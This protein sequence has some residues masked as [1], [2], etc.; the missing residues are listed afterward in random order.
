MQYTGQ[1][2]PGVPAGTPAALNGAKNLITN[3]G[4]NVQIDEITP[5]FSA[6]SLADQWHPNERTTINAGIRVE[7]F[8]YRLDDTVSGYPARA[9]LVRCVRSRGR[10]DGHP[11]YGCSR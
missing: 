1:N 6:A 5:F 4:R 7:N 10:R 8:D 11:M 9:F 2:L 3:D